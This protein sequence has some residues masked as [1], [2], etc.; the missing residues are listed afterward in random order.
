LTEEAAALLKRAP[1]F[2]NES[3]SLDDCARKVL[4][5]IE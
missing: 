4:I 1:R 2:D 3:Q 5:M